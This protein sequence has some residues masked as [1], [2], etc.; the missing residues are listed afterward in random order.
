MTLRYL[1]L[2]DEETG[3]MLM[4]LIYMKPVFEVNYSRKLSSLKNRLVVLPTD[5]ELSVARRNAYLYWQWAF[6]SPPN[7]KLLV[8][9]ELGEENTP[10][11]S[12]APTSTLCISKAPLC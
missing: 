7:V 2:E 12:Q 1:L 3:D 6:E 4:P 8:R 9:Q 10:Q 11:A 5:R